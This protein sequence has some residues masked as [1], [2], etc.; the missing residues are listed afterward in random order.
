MLQSERLN[1]FCTWVA[2]VIDFS[3]Q[4]NL[5][6]SMNPQTLE[7]IGYRIDANGY[8]DYPEIGKISS[9]GLTIIEL[10]QNPWTRDFPEQIQVMMTPMTWS[11]R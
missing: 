2:M 10:N 3:D 6:A 5:G 11:F 4:T 1:F 9:A 7:I 8:I